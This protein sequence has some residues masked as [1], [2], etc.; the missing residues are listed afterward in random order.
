MSEQAEA[1]HG[2]VQAQLYWPMDD[3]ILVAAPMVNHTVV[4]IQR[5]VSGRPNYVLMTMGHF[6]PPLFAGNNEQQLAAAQAAAADAGGYLPV[7]I[8]PVARV[9]VTIE[10]LRDIARVCQNTLDQWDA[11]AG[12]PEHEDEEEQ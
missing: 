1:P 8:Q 3:P 10:H 9:A 4:N 2:E 11:M 5:L 6:S 12:E 7:P